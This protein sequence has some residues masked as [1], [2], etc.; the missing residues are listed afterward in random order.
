MVRSY[1]KIREEEIKLMIEKLEKATSS[2]PS[3]VNLSQL[4]MT[5]TNDIICRVALGRK[6][7]GAEAEEGIDVENIVRTFAAVLG[8]FP[9]GEYIPSLSWVDRICGV[10]H[11]LEEVDKRF[12]DFLERVVKEHEDADK[13]NRSDF[14]DKLLTIQRDKTGQFELEKNA[15]K[16][17]IWVR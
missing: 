5:L 12:D 15:L 13:E 2:S 14:V 8:E 16:L 11:K 17:I 10:D 6:Y 1:E 7:S 4:L 9:I 3:P